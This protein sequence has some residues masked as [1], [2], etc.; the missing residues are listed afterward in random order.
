MSVFH[1][2]FEPNI[3][4]NPCSERSLRHS[5]AC[6][7]CEDIFFS[8]STRSSPPAESG[9]GR[10]RANEFAHAIHG[11]DTPSAPE[12]QMDAAGVDEPF[13]QEER[14]GDCG[15][16]PPEFDAGAAAGGAGFADAAG[17]LVGGGQIRLVGV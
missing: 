14:D 11:S 7:F 16:P 5:S 10:P 2:D 1:L 12:L 6:R 4:R 15:E 17:G 13:D 3:N 8:R 9:V